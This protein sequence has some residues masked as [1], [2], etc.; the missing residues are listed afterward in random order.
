MISRVNILFSVISELQAHT[1][2]V[3][4]NSLL[5]VASFHS[6]MIR[7]IHGLINRILPMVMK[8]VQFT[9]IHFFPCELTMIK[10]CQYFTYSWLITLEPINLYSFIQN[11]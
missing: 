2:V 5:S 9:N 11:H 7:Q 4:E 8:S 1:I 6:I 10:C 3:S